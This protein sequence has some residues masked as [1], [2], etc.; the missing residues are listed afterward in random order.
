MCLPEQGLGA[1]GCEARETG[2]NSDGSVRIR[3][4]VLVASALEEASDKR[5][6]HND[7]G[8]T[9]SAP[10]RNCLTLICW[11]LLEWFSV[12][13]YL[14][15]MFYC[16]DLCE[17]A[18][19]HWNFR[20]MRRDNCTLL[21]KRSGPSAAA[22]LLLYFKQQRAR[23]QRSVP[24]ASSLLVLCTHCRQKLS[25]SAEKNH[26]RGSSADPPQGASA[27]FS[28]LFVP[29][30][31]FASKESVSQIKDPELSDRESRTAL[32]WLGGEKP[33]KL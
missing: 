17:Q 21:A 3:G 27:F 14:G 31:H 18:S 11:R 12:I 26:L 28:I 33:P 20:R 2:L 23:A 24:S 15:L 16:R 13:L 25:Q 1:R 7:R 9:E 29:E 32:W 30:S 22:R 6:H 5:L 19:W 10:L 4:D 8:A